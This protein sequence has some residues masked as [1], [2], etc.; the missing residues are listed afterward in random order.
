[1]SIEDQKFETSYMDVW[2]GSIAET[3]TLKFFYDQPGHM[4]DVCYVWPNGRRALSY[5]S[6]IE[7][8]LIEDGEIKI[9]FST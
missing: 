8:E 6:I 7:K 5:F 4:R 1:M 9:A 3:E 2:E